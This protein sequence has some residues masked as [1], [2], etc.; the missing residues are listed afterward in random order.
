MAAVSFNIDVPSASLLAGNV[1]F[2]TGYE[3]IESVT[4]GSGGASSVT[5]AGIPQYYR[6]L[7]IRGM[8]RSTATGT[9]GSEEVFVRFNGDSTASYSY[10]YLQG[11][12][13]IIGSY[14]STSQ[15]QGNIAMA[16]RDGYATNV[17]SPFVADI[18]D[19]SNTVKN[20]TVRSLR[21]QDT[22]GA[23]FV[24]LMST[25]WYKTSAVSSIT[26]IPESV[27]FKQFSTFSLYGIR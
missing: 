3:H 16:C 12:G 19:Y 2:L 20:T 10:H 18:L 24:S 5:F 14:A 8:V 9:A 22:N 21:G 27:P 25:G 7:Q 4:V 26:I 17:Y 13:S 23:G 11:N 6:H 15:T 1:G